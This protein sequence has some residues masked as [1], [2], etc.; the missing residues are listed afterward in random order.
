MQACSDHKWLSL[1]S[2]KTT[3]MTYGTIIA[4]DDNNDILT[5]LSYALDD[6]FQHVST[7]NRP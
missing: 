6:T 5:A 1:P 3:D 4:C 2:K 7:L